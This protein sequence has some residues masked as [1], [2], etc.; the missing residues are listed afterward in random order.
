MRLKELTR[1]GCNRTHQS[2]KHLFNA[3]VNLW[4]G[5]M[6]QLPMVFLLNLAAGT[7]YIHTTQGHFN[8][9]YSSKDNISEAKTLYDTYCIWE[10][11]ALTGH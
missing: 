4:G 1:T 2:F 9:T 8:A 3:V 5:H 11:S 6:T 7:A 10:I